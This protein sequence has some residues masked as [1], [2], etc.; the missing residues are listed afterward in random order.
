MA[1][2]QIVKYSTLGI[3]IDDM[4]IVTGNR[5]GVPQ[6]YLH[7]QFVNTPICLFTRVGDRLSRISWYLLQ[8]IVDIPTRLK[9]PVILGSTSAR[10]I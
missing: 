1:G 3:A 4:V 10:W 7:P 5:F 8:Y 6:A 2:C 9:A